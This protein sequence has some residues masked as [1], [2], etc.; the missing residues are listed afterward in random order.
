MDRTKNVTRNILWGFLSRVIQ[1]L[2]PFFTRTAILYVLGS[3]YLGLSSLFVSVLGMLNLSELGLSS[4]IIYSMYKPLA[5][6]D[7]DK[8]CELLS[9]YRKCY[10]VVGTIILAGGLALMPFLK[11]FI[12]G[13]YPKD[14]NIYIIYL[15]YLFNTVVSYFLFAYKKALLQA[16]QRAD[17]ESNIT[18]LISIV[19]HLLQVAAVLLFKSYYTY[20]FILPCMTLLN[21]LMISRTVKKMYPQFVCRGIL[22]KVERQNLFRQIK[23]LV[24]QKIGN[25]VLGS[26]DNIVISSFFGLTILAYYNNYYFIASS[27]FGVIAV[28]SNSLKLSIG[29]VIATESIEKNYDNFKTFNLLYTMMVSWLSIGY[30]CCVQ[31][32]MLIWVGKDKMFSDGMA[33]L[34]AIYIFISKWCDMLYVYQ[35]AKGMWWRMRWVP[36]AAAVVNLVTNI[37][38]CMWIGLPGILISTIISIIFIYDIGYSKILYA[39]YFTGQ[40]EYTRYVIRQLYYLAA[41]VTLWGFCYGI[42][43]CLRA[44]TWPLQV[45]QA[46]LCIF[47]ASVVM[48]LEYA[49]LPEF[50]KAK[51]YL[52]KI[53]K[54]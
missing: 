32:F 41:Q 36:M 34:F 21:N 38:L 23:G 20:L 28:V 7:D 4:A 13:E 40:G 1:T 14:V 12:T 51:K 8:V 29:N 18:S 37:L 26:V 52:L 10:Y 9:F 39:D 47:L 44:K 16:N 5:E 19:Q 33:L 24:F 27:L 30:L 53:I 15:V 48:I 2:I 17:V 50:D 22:G 49:W 25:V 42:C 6:G 45:L 43:F 3:L 31:P 35:E 54:R 46:I 11:Y